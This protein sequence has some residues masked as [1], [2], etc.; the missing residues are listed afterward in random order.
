[1]EECSNKDLLDKYKK[2]DTFKNKTDFNKSNREIEED[3][4][5]PICFDILNYDKSKLVSCPKCKNYIHVN[6]MK[7]W[8]KKHTTC[9][10]CRHDVWKNYG[11]EKVGPYDKYIKLDEIE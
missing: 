11:K 3:D 4:D 2:K 8:L 9:V 10:Y 6:C 1:M 5:C 7:K